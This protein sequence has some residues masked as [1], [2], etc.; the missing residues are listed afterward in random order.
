MDTLTASDICIDCNLCCSSNLGIRIYPD[1]YEGLK[2]DLLNVIQLR[3]DDA[4]WNAYMDFSSSGGTCP[5]LGEDGKCGIYNKRPHVCRSFKC[6]VLNQYEQGE[7][8]TKEVQDLIQTVKDGDK[9]LWNTRF[10]TNTTTYKKDDLDPYNHTEFPDFLTE[11][12]C[13]HIAKILT[14]DESK[15]LA[16]PNEDPNQFYQGTTKQYS[17]YNLL[18]H[19]DIRPL[20]IP[21]RIFDLP[22]YADFDE[23]WVQCWGNIL[24]QNESIKT[25]THADEEYQNKLLACSIYLDGLDPC[26]TH[27][28]GEPQLNVRGTLHCAGMLYPHEVKTNIHS[29]P[30]ISIA[31]DIYHNHERDLDQYKRFLHIKRPNKEK[32]IY[33]THYKGMSIVVK[34]SRTNTLLEFG[35]TWLIQTIIDNKDPFNTIVFPYV[36]QL[37]EVSNRV[38]DP[39]S[40]L[41]LG[42]GGG[43]IPSYFSANT[44]CTDIDVVDINPQLKNIA[45]EYFHM[46][47]S[48]NVIIDDAFQWIHTNAA[49][50]YDIIILD[51]GT[52]QTEFKYTDKLYKGIK[53][54]LTPRGILALW[55]VWDSNPGQIG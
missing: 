18:T 51:L 34:K 19:P 52:D 16:I 32:V 23:L 35:D 37:C 14:R 44:K 28:D 10:M 38:K 4:P 8:D 6:G 49:K 30:R 48:I 54:K 27:W 29:T 11:E 7:I 20:N 17:V 31:M 42:L 13:E 21:E 41:V 40:I 36:Q 5:Q 2:N 22:I 15:I 24:H 55:V 1:E 47:E 33:E 46:P 39:E 45:H 9:N 3:E 25:H 26:Y 12:E 53:N 50:R 43:V